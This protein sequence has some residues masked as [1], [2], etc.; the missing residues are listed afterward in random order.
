MITIKV[1]KPPLQ[2]GPPPRLAY[3]LVVFLIRETEADETS[4]PDDTVSSNFYLM[5]ML[6]GCDEIESCF[7]AMI[8]E[9]LC[10]GLR[11][12]AIISCKSRAILFKYHQQ[13]FVIH[14]QGQDLLLSCLIQSM[15]RTISLSFSFILKSEISFQFLLLPR[16]IIVDKKKA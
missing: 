4:H 10:V 6:M 13:K 14:F 11:W 2:L 3:P 9:G 8:N 15:T 1:P 5:V 7:A 12:F 16:E